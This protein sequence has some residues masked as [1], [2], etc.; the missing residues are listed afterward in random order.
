MELG[1]R[2]RAFAAFVRRRSFVGAA[3]ELRISQP[4][5]SQH[6]ADM[7]R[8]LRVKL[9]ERRSGALTTAGELLAS[10]VLRAEALLAQ[11]ARCVRALHEPETGSLSIIAS[12][13]PG[14][15]LLPQ[16]IAK[17]QRLHPGVTIGFELD[18]AKEVA[19]AIRSH[20]AEIGVVG[21]FVTAPEIE[22]EPLID[23]EIVIVGPPSL[24]RKRL[25]RDEIEELTWI[26]REEGSG[27]SA[28]GEAIIGDLGIIPRRRLALPSWEAIK[29]AVRGGCGIAAISRLAVT[30]ELEIGS[31]AI[32]PILASKAR[33]NFSII[34]T[35]DAALTPAAEHFL[36]LLRERC[37]K[38][39]RR[40]R[41]N[42]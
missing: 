31:L 9:I 6:I 10:H 22:V 26:S 42:S 24:A 35:R 5:V 41:K 33:R 32:L 11:G 27:T 23:D 28:L 36:D 21:A 34:R 39:A 18:T 15:Y 1:A 25:S 30:E 13:T 29:L 20:R 3:A 17:F 8:D 14:T 19:N 16:V 37:A 38:P 7:E 2:L 40:L 12:G 4:A